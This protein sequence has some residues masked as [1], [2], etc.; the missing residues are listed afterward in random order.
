MLPLQP[1]QEDCQ[2]TGHRMAKEQGQGAGWTT[3]KTSGSPP[4]TGHQGEN[5]GQ[6]PSQV[7]GL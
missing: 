6:S 1:R 4:S 5:S 7:S 2:T 3:F